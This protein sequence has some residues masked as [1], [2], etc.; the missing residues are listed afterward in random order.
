MRQVINNLLTNAVKFSHRGTTITVRVMKQNGFNII[1]VKDQGQGIPENEI[2][3]LFQ[4]FSR[5][6]VQSTAG[7][8]STG[9]GLAIVRNIVNAHKGEIRVES[10]VGEGTVFT[11]SLPVVQEE[12]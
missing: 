7:E 5:T 3:L 1:E 6:S 2:P 9:L 11:V 12:G 8:K 4:P 10:K